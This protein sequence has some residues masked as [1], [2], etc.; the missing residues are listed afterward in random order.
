MSDVLK[1]MQDRQEIIDLTIAYGWLLD[2]GPR[3]RLDTVFAEDAVAD[4]MGLVFE[5]L[6]AIIEKVSS[7]LGVLD[8][9][10]HIVTNQQGTIDGDTATCKCY[11]H[12]Q[13]TVYG[14]EGGEN[15]VVAGRYEDELIRTP[16]G[17]RITFRKLISDWTEGNPK[18]RDGRKE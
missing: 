10:Q 11:L 6:P 16:D 12:A 14:L 5:G 17:W 2:H 3:E 7:A 4:Y 18:V 1:E 8:I 13:H 9:S 15:M